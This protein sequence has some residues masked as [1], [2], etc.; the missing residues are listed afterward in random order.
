[1][2]PRA[3]QAGQ[4]PTRTM[5]PFVPCSLRQL[6]GERLISAAAKAVLIN[7]ANRAVVLNR[8]ESIPIDLL[9]G[10]LLAI[11]TDR[12]WETRGVRLTVSF[13]D[14]PG[15]DLQS[16]ILLHM[17]AW[18]E[19]ANVR[20]DLT[21]RIGQ[22]RIA[23][24]LEG[25]WSYLGTDILE[26]PEDEPTMNLHGFTMHTP[27]SEMRRVVLHE[28]GHTLGFP[29]EHLRQ[30][31]VER[32]VEWK[33]IDFYAATKGWSAAQTRAQIL[34]PISDAMLSKSAGEGQ[35]SIMCHEIPGTLTKDGTPIWGGDDI[36]AADAA[37]A[38]ACY[39]K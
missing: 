19:R 13:V 28:T 36:N 22:V 30:A 37:L 18:G 10:A 27:E 33:V 34:T 17:N 9:D 15:A 39:P 12:K 29:H 5:A 26:I 35:D 16:L 4:Q 20:F 24:G 8:V 14:G 31:M 1:M 7:L 21:G 38:A 11:L 3:D 32:L 2:G 23:R 6:Q 25:H